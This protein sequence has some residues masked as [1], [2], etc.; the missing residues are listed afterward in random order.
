LSRQKA[1]PS[2]RPLLSRQK[3]CPSV[4]S[5]SICRILSACRIRRFR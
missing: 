2:V 5:L 3:A 4:G 1:C